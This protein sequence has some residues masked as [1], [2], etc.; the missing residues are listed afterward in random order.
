MINSNEGYQEENEGYQE[1]HN[2]RKQYD[3]ESDSQEMGFKNW[4]DVDS[5][6]DPDDTNFVKRVKYA[7]KENVLKPADRIVTGFR[8][9][10]RNWRAN[11]NDPKNIKKQIEH[12]DQIG[13]TRTALL[14]AKGESEIG[15]F[16]ILNSKT[17]SG[18]VYDN[19]VSGE[20][21]KPLRKVTNFLNIKPMKEIYVVKVMVDGVQK[22]IILAFYTS[23]SAIEDGANPNIVR[24]LENK[25]PFAIIKKDG[26]LEEIAGPVG[27]LNLS[28][29][30]FDLIEEVSR[31]FDE[32]TGEYDENRSW[33][34]NPE[35]AEWLT[36]IAVMHSIKKLLQTLGYE[37]YDEES[38]QLFSW[39]SNEYTR[40]N[41]EN[42][43][44][45]FPK[46]PLAVITDFTID[47][48]SP[49]GHQILANLM[50]QLHLPPSKEQLEAYKMANRRAKGELMAK[51]IETNIKSLAEKGGSKT[52]KKRSKR[53]KKTKKRTNKKTNK[54]RKHRSNKSKKK[55]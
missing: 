14:Q 41:I 42:L 32:T 43:K 17:P 47:S 23:I 27:F 24:I 50:G 13:K 9:G 11:L 26:R 38:L 39:N 49:N 46:E 3:S 1:E 28:E 35:T 16:S 29:N 54:R 44:R 22:I 8:R 21:P 51:N 2:K 6:L 18:T 30:N 45:K 48:T 40:E 53:N 15:F 12:L 37:N 33:E 55:R 25:M 36:K 4:I 34:W 19:I 52:K 20:D 31:F 5:S 7:V 10:W